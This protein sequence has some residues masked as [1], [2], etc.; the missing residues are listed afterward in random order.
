LFHLRIS[1]ID[2]IMRKEARKS[3]VIK[4]KNP[5]FNSIHF[6]LFQE[7]EMKAFVKLMTLIIVFSFIVSCGGTPATTQAPQ[8]TQAPA[9]PVLLATATM[10]PVTEPQLSENEQWA[11]DNGL[12]PYQPETDDWAAIEAAAKLEG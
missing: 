3:K 10:A 6:R 9:V 11:K 5:V 7:E 12:G 8:A 1:Y 2:V 4:G